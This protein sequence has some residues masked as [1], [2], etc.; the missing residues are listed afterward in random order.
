MEHIQFLGTPSSNRQIL[1][2]QLDTTTCQDMHDRHA[3]L[4]CQMAVSKIELMVLYYAFLRSTLAL[5]CC[6]ACTCCG[7]DGL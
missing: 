2:I 3:G 7:A 4:Q 6:R 5:Q 1:C